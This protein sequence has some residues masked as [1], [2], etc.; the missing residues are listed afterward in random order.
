MSRRRFDSR[1]ST[2]F[3]D[4]ARTGTTY[5]SSPIETRNVFRMAN[6]T[7]SVTTDPIQDTEAIVRQRSWELVG[8][9][10]ASDAERRSRFPQGRSA[11]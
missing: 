7:V 9:R 3:A 2:G 4:L 5:R 1:P 10:R 6:D 11:S 8:Y